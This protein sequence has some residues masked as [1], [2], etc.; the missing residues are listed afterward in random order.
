MRRAIL[1]VLAGGLLLTGAACDSDADT[2]EIAAPAAT[3]A[4]AAPASTAPAPDYSADTEK[5]CGRLD[6]IFSAAL[7]GE[8]GAA[9]G[10]MIAQK[11]AKQAEEAAK[12]EKAAAAELK[13]VGAQI[14]EETVA[15]QDPELKAAG[16]T[17]AAKIEKSAQNRDY[18]EKVKTSKDL[19]RTLK[20]QVQ[21][22]LSP[23]TGYCA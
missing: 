13:S 2:S 22:W 17:S 9:M 19:D 20:T 5:V 3:T 21:E 8:F 15:A 11:E 7:A 18:I 1:A 4:P 16:E 10:K 12:A 6:K 23:V 14:R